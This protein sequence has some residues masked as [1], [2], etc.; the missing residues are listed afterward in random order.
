[1]SVQYLSTRTYAYDWPTVHQTIERFE[2]DNQWEVASRIVSQAVAVTSNPA[3]K[4][5]ETLEK[6]AGYHA[7]LT[8]L[9][10][11]CRV[12]LAHARRT[13]ARS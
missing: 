13:G 9:A 7:Q 8:N 2:Q 10:C 6:I 4:S 3:G 11:E 12:C 1:M 5:P